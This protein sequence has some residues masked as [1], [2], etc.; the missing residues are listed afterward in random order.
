VPTPPD[1]PTEHRILGHHALLVL[2]GLAQHRLDV[3][4]GLRGM[5]AGR[6][7]PQVL[8]HDDD[9]EDHQLREVG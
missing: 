8:A 1:Q 6:L 3:L 4:V 5:R 9:R 7:G 2:Q